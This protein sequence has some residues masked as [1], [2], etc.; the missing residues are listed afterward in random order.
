MASPELERLVAI[1]KLKREPPA[2]A[3]FEGLVQ[4]GSARLADAL[5]EE[6]SVESRFDLA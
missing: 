1:G 6:F 2:R 4:S 3:E 5:N